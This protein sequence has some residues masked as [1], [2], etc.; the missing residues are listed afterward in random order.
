MEC[1]VA[2]G[3]TS[4][5]R[6]TFLCA[7]LVSFTTITEYAGTLTVTLDEGGVATFDSVNVEAVIV[8]CVLL[9]R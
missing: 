6:G 3:N 8:L 2:G 1:L 4:P 5:L 7:Q 9:S